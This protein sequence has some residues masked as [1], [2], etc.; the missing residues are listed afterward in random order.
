MQVLWQLHIDWDEPIDSGLQ[1]EWNTI[2]TD[3]QQLSGLTIDRYYFQ[4][5][6]REGIQLHVFADASMKAY[7]AVAFLTS[8]D[9][10]TLTM[11]KNRVAPLKSFPS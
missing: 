11:A 1:E 10:A 4:H 2:L 3:L 7:G 6:T 5:F 9:H 8:G